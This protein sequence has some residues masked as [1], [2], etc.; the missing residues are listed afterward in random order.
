[1]DAAAALSSAIDSVEDL[2]LLKGPRDYTIV[3]FPR[4]D[5]VREIHGGM[6]DADNRVFYLN[7]ISS[8]DS[9]HHEA[10]HWV[11]MNNGF[12]FMD[13]SAFPIFGRALDEILADL[14][15]NTLERKVD[16][17][18]L[19][20]ADDARNIASCLHMKRRQFE[21]QAGHYLAS[22]KK[23]GRADDPVVLFTAAYL[24]SI[25]TAAYLT[26]KV[27]ELEECFNHNR[28][29][30]QNAYQE[31]DALW[32][33]QGNDII[34]RGIA[35]ALGERAA[36]VLFNK[37]Y[38]PQKILNDMKESGPLDPMQLYWKVIVPKL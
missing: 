20:N 32:K 19:M 4:D 5:L 8:S 14:C 23:A 22:A 36:A 10:A 11:L 37:G 9:L 30:M 21:I 34:E 16:M 33:K 12:K 25:P 1:M 27:I 24:V 38:H 13:K 18:V 26:M 15:V 2:L 29:M 6:L 3:Q 31:F 35:S 28:Q 17:R 7:D